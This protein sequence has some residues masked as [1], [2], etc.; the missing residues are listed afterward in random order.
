MFETLF[1]KNNPFNKTL[2]DVLFNA[3][4]MNIAFIAVLTVIAVRNSHTFIDGLFGSG[5]YN[6]IFGFSREDQQIIG[7]LNELNGVKDSISK[8]IAAC[9]A[10]ETDIFRKIEII[11]VKLEH[12]I[13]SCTTL[14]K[15][16]ADSIS[17]MSDDLNNLKNKIKVKELS[18][19]TEINDSF[20]DKIEVRNN[21]DISNTIDIAIAKT[22][23]N[24]NS[25]IFEVCRHF[26]K[27]KSIF[28]ELV[29]L[30]E[31]EKVETGTITAPVRRVLKGSGIFNGIS[32]TLVNYIP[33][34]SLIPTSYIL[35]TLSFLGSFYLQNHKV[36]NEFIKA[37]FTNKS[38]IDKIKDIFI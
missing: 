5:L 4:T 10:S 8:L 11:E 24:L 38:T 30:P 34:I 36:I 16:L 22:N 9:D 3:D 1:S 18:G 6:K 15:Q 23:E 32:D 13:A 2:F 20:G 14:P 19:V 17:L 21:T 12:I 31:L 33:P 35:P 29:K 25:S 37:A 27:R 28:S 26:P 7:L